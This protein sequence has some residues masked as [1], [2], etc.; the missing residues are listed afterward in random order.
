LLE[1]QVS[2]LTVPPL[3]GNFCLEEISDP[4]PKKFS[5]S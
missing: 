1:V 4:T 5:L 3:E 2:N